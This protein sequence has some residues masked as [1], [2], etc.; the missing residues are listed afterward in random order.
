MSAPPASVPPQQPPPPTKEIIV[1]VDSD[2]ELSDLEGYDTDPERHSATVADDGDPGDLSE[3]DPD[4]PE[5]WGTESLLEDMVGELATDESESGLFAARRMVTRGDKLIWAHKDTEE[6]N[7]LRSFLKNNGDDVFV[8]EIICRRGV[9]ARRCITAFKVRPVCWAFRFSRLASGKKEVDLRIQPS[10]L[11]N[12]SDRALLPLLRHILKKEMMKRSR[13]PHVSTVEHVVELLK[14]SKQ[15]VV[16]TGAGV[17]SIGCSPRSGALTRARYPR[18]WEFLT[19]DRK[20]VGCI[21][22]W[23]ASV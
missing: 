16:L 11:D 14:K 10:F 4:D 2:S 7:E 1:I 9:S 8:D 12:A 22:G 13:L 15:I 5:A 17:G 20:V 18:L 23:K 19:L 3:G 6:S 21:P